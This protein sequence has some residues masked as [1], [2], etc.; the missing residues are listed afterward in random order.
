MI[1]FPKTTG[2]AVLH[3][4]HMVREIIALFW[5]NPDERE[6][7]LFKQHCQGPFRIIELV[8]GCEVELS[9]FGDFVQSEQGIVR[10]GNDNEERPALTQDTPDR[11][12]ET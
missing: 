11:L 12:I 10:I 4:V 8:S 3:P 1:V 2:P 7:A 5:E 9:E 6:T